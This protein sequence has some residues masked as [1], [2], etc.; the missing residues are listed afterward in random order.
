VLAFPENCTRW[1]GFNYMY[2]CWST[3]KIITFIFQI[4]EFTFQQIDIIF[5]IVEVTKSSH[6]WGHICWHGFLDKHNYDI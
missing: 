3:I 1:F 2:L 4:V 5:Q 6:F